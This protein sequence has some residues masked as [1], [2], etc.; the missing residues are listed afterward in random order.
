RREKR[1][2]GWRDFQK[3]GSKTKASKTWKQE[4]ASSSDKPK[5]GQLGGEDYRKEWK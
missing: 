4:T 1:G 3:G 5:F 2:G